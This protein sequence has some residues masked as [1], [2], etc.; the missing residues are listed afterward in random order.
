MN[1]IAACYLPPLISLK[2]IFQRRRGV[3][4]GIY[5]VGILL[6]LLSYS[7]TKSVYYES[8]LL[9]ILAQQLNL[10]LSL[11]SFLVSFMAASVRSSTVLFLSQD[12]SIL[13]KAPIS[14]FRLFVFR[15]IQIFAGTQWSMW[16]LLFPFFLG[17]LLGANHSLMPII[18]TFN[19]L[20]AQVSGT[21]LAILLVTI[22]AGISPVNRFREG[23]MALLVLILLG[24]ST[25]SFYS[26]FLPN[27]KSLSGMSV[28]SV[29]SKIKMAPSL[30]SVTFFWSGISIASLLCSGVFFSRNYQKALSRLSDHRR[31]ATRISI[32]FPRLIPIPGSLRANASKEFRL[33]LRNPSQI[34]QM[35]IFLGGVFMYLIQAKSLGAINSIPENAI[36]YWDS[37]K[38]V[39]HSSISGML[40]CGMCSRFVF[41]SFSLEGGSIWIYQ[42]AP[43]S[44]KSLL[45][46]RIIIWSGLLLSVGLILLLA[47][48]FALSISIEGLIWNV[49]IF[50]LSVPVL[51]TIASVCGALFVRFDWEHP[52]AVTGGWGSLLT[53]LFCTCITIALITACVSILVLRFIDIPDLSGF[54]SELIIQG[55]IVSSI[56]VLAIL[57]VNSAL[58]IGVGAI[59]TFGEV[60]ALRKGKYLKNLK[61]N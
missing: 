7:I 23:S 39:I 57:F 13:L 59:E 26:E 11:G 37:G 60:K 9:I 54:N 42:A 46:Q 33:F 58:K 19:T 24:L 32:S 4:R 49:F 29:L 18:I 28:T 8:E 61:K 35:L 14:Q 6:L 52:G 31:E 1:Q 15:F 43:I 25:F 2:N 44:A 55:G 34:L 38:A 5:G 50:S 16:L 41:P 36:T 10:S 53:F 27:A 21:A 40:L 45:R 51:V 48:G 30:F 3:R 17:L 12:S 22:A 47:I 20:L 56:T